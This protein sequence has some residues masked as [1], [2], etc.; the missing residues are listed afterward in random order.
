MRTKREPELSLPLT[1]TQREVLW[2]LAQR[3]TQGQ[4]VAVQYS[5]LGSADWG[6]SGA[7]VALLEAMQAGAWEAARAHR[8]AAG[9]NDLLLTFFLAVTDE[10]GAKTAYWLALRSPF[11]LYDTARLLAFG[12]VAELPPTTFF[13]LGKA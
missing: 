9:T 10:A 5:L 6:E 4:A 1:S 8:A 12:R 13:S 2:E 3:V 7:P 11:E